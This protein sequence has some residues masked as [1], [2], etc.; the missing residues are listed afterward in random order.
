MQSAQVSA[1]CRPRVLVIEDDV[2]LAS[3][4]RDGLE[5]EHYA[6]TLA[7]DGLSGLES[8]NEQSFQTVLLDIMLPEID[9]FDVVSAMRKAGNK[10]P[11][12]MLTAR[13]SISDK[14]RGFDCGIEDFVTKP[15][16]F[17]ELLA[18]VRVLVRR[19]PAQSRQ[20]QV[21]DLVMDLDSY[22]V[23]RSGEPIA[24]T[25]TEFSILQ[26]LMRDC[27]R[28]IPRS[29][30][31]RAGWGPRAVI[32]DNNLDVTMSTLRAKVDKGRCQRLIRTVRG[33]GYRVEIPRD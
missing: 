7:H 31:V 27:G 25:R 20:W 4:L 2:E 23:S 30:L 28:V 16:S 12:L 18:R 21:A 22:Q 29:E 26:A 17:L 5:H 6:V 33:F 14:I 13:D 24:L 9:G 15:F 11:I 1:A 10:T 19:A 3:V 8:A 32:D